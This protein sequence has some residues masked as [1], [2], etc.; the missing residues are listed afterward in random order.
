MAITKARGFNRGRTYND[1]RQIAG[2]S[3]VVPLGVSGNAGIYAFPGRGTPWQS[4][5]TGSFHRGYGYNVTTYPAT[6]SDNGQYTIY[7]EN[8]GSL[9]EYYASGGFCVSM[10]ARYIPQY[11]QAL[12]SDGTNFICANTTLLSATTPDLVNYTVTNNTGAGQNV[13]YSGGR[14]TYQ[15][16][17]ILVGAGAPYVSQG[18]G[19]GGTWTTLSMGAA[20]SNMTCISA[21]FHNGQYYIY[22]FNG[23]NGGAVCRTADTNWTLTGSTMVYNAAGTINA[24]EYMDW[25]ADVGCF[26]GACTR[27]RAN[28]AAQ[29]GIVR[30]VDGTNWTEAFS[31]TT[32]TTGLMG[33]ATNGSGTAVA[34]GY[35]GYI[36]TST[37]GTASTWTPVTS[38]Q[39]TERF[40]SVKWYNGEFVAITQY[41]GTATSPN[42][43]VWTWTA[44][45]QALLGGGLIGL[46]LFIHSDGLYAYMRGATSQQYVIK[47]LGNRQWQTILYVYTGTTNNAS[48]ASV[49]VGIFFGDAPNASNFVLN[50]NNMAGIHMTPSGA[51]VVQST[52]TALWAFGAQVSFVQDTDWHRI[53]VEGIS[54]PGQTN[55]T[56]TF[57]IYYDGVRV[58]GPSS[59]RVASNTTQRLYLCSSSSSWNFMCDAIVTNFTGPRN[60]GLTNDIQIRPRQ[61][62]TD[63]QAQWDKL[64]PTSPTN[65]AAAVGNGSVVLA[66]SS[67][68]SSVVGTTDIYG[69]TAVSGVPGYRISAV[70]AQM[71]FQ[72]AGLTTPS[73]EL[74]VVEGGS[75][76][77][78][79]TA[80]LNGTTTELVTL[81]ALYP[82]KLDGNS[83]TPETLSNA[84]VQIRQSA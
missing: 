8:V 59:N 15:N 81:T 57:N 37:D 35:N 62:S 73:A 9:Q 80:V 68:Q 22:G 41:G 36:V 29:A 45:P 67:V 47:Y 60:V 31:T 70:Q 44:A 30:S 23:N 52:S 7:L 26:L 42:G 25:F 64:P 38:G 74:S 56:F 82:T 39:T 20:Q 75:S 16:G 18:T 65:V 69:G 33:V 48:A 1:L 63:V 49:P 71:T 55:P 76:L 77:P 2:G 28:A 32:S 4:T 58:A 46:E 3:S 14:L 79:Q 54:V 83:W 13:G 11:W 40:T 66:N 34:V 43:L 6:S 10:K 50:G 17:M 24:I 61:L 5:S 78:I 51:Y 19:P 21:V 72:R 53:S 84:Q 27:N 12:G